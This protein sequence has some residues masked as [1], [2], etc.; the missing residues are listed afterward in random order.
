MR[1]RADYPVLPEQAFY[2]AGNRQFL[3]PYEAVRTAVDP[4]GTL[5][6]F[7]HSTYRAPAERGKWDRGALE[8]DP[9]PVGWETLNT[10]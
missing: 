1:W 7:L 6:G 9:A 8:V 3:L 5:L 4:H 2:S 10:N